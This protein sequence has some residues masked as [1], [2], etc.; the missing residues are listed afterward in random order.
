MT[1]QKFQRLL[2]G[3][4]CFQGNNKNIN[5]LRSIK[6]EVNMV[7][8]INNNDD[9]NKRNANFHIPGRIVKFEMNISIIVFCNNQ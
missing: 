1:L 4:L 2:M 7:I 9:S 8:K 6:R 5:I 3:I